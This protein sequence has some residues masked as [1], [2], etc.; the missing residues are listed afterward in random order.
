M[1][2]HGELNLPY[3]PRDWPWV[4]SLSTMLLAWVMVLSQGCG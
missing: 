2:L 3:K 4:M 1:M